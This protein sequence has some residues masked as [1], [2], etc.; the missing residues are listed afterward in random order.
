MNIFHSQVPFLEQTVFIIYTELI[1]QLW[2]T[3]S[4]TCTCAETL[5]VQPRVVK[6]TDQYSMNFSVRR[7]FTLTHTPNTHTC[8]V[9]NKI[10]KWHN[11]P[12]RRGSLETVSMITSVLFTG[13]VELIIYMHLTE[14]LK[15]IRFYSRIDYVAPRNLAKQ[16]CFSFKTTIREGQETTLGLIW[17]T[18]DIKIGLEVHLSFLISQKPAW[19]LVWG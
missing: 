4:S 19:V 18:V 6:Y 12:S 11:M 8:L 15:S 7:N 1:I 10:R 14:I 9:S 3:T 2:V 16:T 5:F 13:L 17:M